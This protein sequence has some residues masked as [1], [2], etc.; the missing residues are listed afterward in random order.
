M[1]FVSI[2]GLTSDTIGLISSHNDVW[3]QH[4][5][6][7]NKVSLPGFTYMGIE[8]KRNE[9]VINYGG[10]TSTSESDY[11]K[12]L[13]D[14]LNKKTGK[15]IKFSY[16]DDVYYGDDDILYSEN[17]NTDRAVATVDYSSDDA[18]T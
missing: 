2:S 14:M 5:L 13:G 16:R 8:E 12:G 3:V 7:I 11:L 1:P 18:K 10:K 17:F 4:L 6:P 15:P 9:I